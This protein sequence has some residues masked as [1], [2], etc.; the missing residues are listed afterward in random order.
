MRSLI[1]ALT[2]LAATA[3]TAGEAYIT[4]SDPMKASQIVSIRQAC[5]DLSRVVDI[6][7]ERIGDDIDDGEERAIS[8]EELVADV[9]DSVVHE[10]SIGPMCIFSLGEGHGAFL[11]STSGDAFVGLAGRAIIMYSDVN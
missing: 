9:V 11:L 2:M 8:Y 4:D 5:G 3:A 10:E 6:F 1:L 7:R